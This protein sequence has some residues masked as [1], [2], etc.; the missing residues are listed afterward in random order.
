MKKLGY[1]MFALFVSLC[2]SAG[3]A[4]AGAARTTYPVVF[5]HGMGGFDNILGYDY[6]GDDYGTF[7]GDPCDAFLEVYCNGDIDSGPEGVRRAGASRSRPP[8]CAGSTSPTT[9]RASWPPPAPRA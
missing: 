4:R 2:V 8:R 1:A 7:V 5:A 6:W 9:S 3:A